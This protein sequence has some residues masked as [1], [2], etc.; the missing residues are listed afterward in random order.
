MDLWSFIFWVK[1]KRVCKI[2]NP[3]EYNLNYSNI[4]FQYYFYSEEKSSNVSKS[5]LFKKLFK[6]FNYHYRYKIHINSKTAFVKKFN[7]FLIDEKK[8]FGNCYSC[9]IFFLGKYY[10]IYNAG[11]CKNNFDKFVKIRYNIFKKKKNIFINSNWIS[12]NI[13][14]DII[15]NKNQKTLKKLL[16]KKNNENSYID[17]FVSRKCSVFVSNNLSTTSRFEILY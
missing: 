10:N 17:K 6:K 8:C 3:N 7:L 12:E 16:L 11:N 15:K 9:Y 2:T 1:K 13:F 14:I 5:F 4:F